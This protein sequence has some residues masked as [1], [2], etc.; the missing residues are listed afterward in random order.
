MGKDVLSQSEIDSIINALS[1]GDLSSKQQDDE[2]LQA[3]KVVPY[4]FRRPNKFSKDQMRTLKN[5]HENF[6]RMLTN[7]L[8]AYLRIPAAVKLESASQVIYEEFICSLPLPTLVTV[9]RLSENNGSALLETNS[10]FTFPIIDILF[11]GEGKIIKQA[12]ELTEIELSVLRRVNEKVLNNLRYAW[13]DI[14]DISPLIESLDTNPQFSQLLASNEAVALL[15]FSTNIAGNDG[16]I[17]LC[18]PYITLEPVLTRL[19]AQNWHTR[20]SKM[21]WDMTKALKNLEK[22]LKFIKVELTAVL[23]S[24]TITV[25]DFL[26]FEEGDIILLDRQVDKPVDLCL[27]G[28]PKFKINLGTLSTKMAGVITDIIFEEEE[29]E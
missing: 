18:L 26:N 22:K 3:H 2:L 12:R 25:S 24:T 15:S 9:F 23:G 28:R 13:E 17:N 8:T 4:D 20:Q 16:F 7:F 29:T 10:F 11:G 14:A 19:S 27:E 21:D 6:A 5:I 1:S